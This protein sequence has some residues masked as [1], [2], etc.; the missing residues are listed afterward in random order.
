MKTR[1]DK[2]LLDLT[3]LKILSIEYQLTWAEFPTLDEG[4]LVYAIDHGILKGEVSQY[5]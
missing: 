5:H 3:S 1:Q 2:K 4:T